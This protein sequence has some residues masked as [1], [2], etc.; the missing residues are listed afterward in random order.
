[1]R[2][3]PVLFLALARPDLLL[4]RPGWGG[5]LP[6]YTALSLEALSAEDSSEL[7]A[8]LLE[9]EGIEPSRV[10]ETAEGNP[11]FI[12]EL[13][14]SVVE[15][16][17]DDTR[18]LPTTIRELVSARLDALPAD[19][20][21]VLLDAAVIGKVFWRGALGRLS[22][23]ASRLDTALDS[24]ESRDLIR[25]ESFSWIEGEEQFTFKHVMIREVAYAT[26]PRAQ[27]KELHVSAARFLE[28][29]TSGSAATATALAHHWTEAGDFDRA[30]QY[31]LRAADQAARGWAKDE[32]TSLYGEALGLLPEDDERRREIGRKQALAA[33]ATV[34][35]RDMR[36]G[37]QPEAE[38]S[39]R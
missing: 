38:T 27:R 15:R 14:A 11:L 3:V 28:D 26:L 10:V 1:V 29:A 2:D 7:A 4:A 8:R 9:D 31:I 13:V 12:E 18:T 23:D 36:L 37:P 32:A 20:R 22:G 6:A 33:A 35:I 5:G 16:A 17:G 30:V 24:L 19:E 21:A 39:D 34:H 25:R